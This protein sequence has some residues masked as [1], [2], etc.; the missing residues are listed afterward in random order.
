MKEKIEHVFKTHPK[1]EEV[2]TTSDELIFLNGHDA[3]N[4][5]KTLKDT[6]VKKVVK[7]YKEETSNEDASYPEGDP[8][9]KWKA[10]ELRA[11]MDEK[12]IEYEGDDNK[13]DLITKIV[14]AAE[15]KD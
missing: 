8:S 13:S 9:M 10:D 3:Q 6:E 4:H 12:K 15:N 11:Y 2:F 1:A 7:A 14:Q 5:A